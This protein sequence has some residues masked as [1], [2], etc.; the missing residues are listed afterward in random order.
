MLGCRTA[1]GPGTEE[2]DLDLELQREA[3]A[4]AS[5]QDAPAAT[6]ETATAAA[7]EAPKGKLTRFD[8]LRG[9]TRNGAGFRVLARETPD[10]GRVVAFEF[11]G[12]LTLGDESYKGGKFG[13]VALVAFDAEGKLRWSKRLD[14]KD[15]HYVAALEVAA[16][17]DI[18]IG[19]SFGQQGMILTRLSS[20]GE[21]LWTFEPEKEPK[22][23]EVS[24]FVL[25]AQGDVVVS[26]LF[27]R[28]LQLPG[29]DPMKSRYFDG[30]VGKLDGQ[31]G[32]IRWIQ[33]FSSVEAKASAVYVAPETGD[34]F[35]GGD[36]RKFLK[37]GGKELSGKRAFFFARFSP[38]GQVQFLAEVIGRFAGNVISIQPIAG[39]VAVL[40]LRDPKNSEL[41]ALS[42]KDGTIRWVAEDTDEGGALV[43]D[44]NRR[45][46]AVHYAVHD[47]DP[48]FGSTRIL[49]REIE[50]EDRVRTV[51]AIDAGDYVFMSRG[52]VRRAADGAILISG[53]L[54]DDA[55][56][57]DGF[58][59]YLLDLAPDARRVNLASIP[60]TGKGSGS[61][62]KQVL[63]KK[64]VWRDLRIAVQ[65]QRRQLLTCVADPS[66]I[67]A[68]FSLQPDGTVSEVT[69]LGELSEEQSAC[70][71]A[72][73]QE[74]R[75]CPYE[76]G[77]YK[78]RLSQLR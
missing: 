7:A 64:Q 30:Y 15:Y 40:H 54:R 57:N 11:D 34:I 77:P 56:D 67:G 26:G 36:Y 19:G 18:L 63:P 17:G 33:Q 47:A 12:T 42:E 59:P 69:V 3:E 1:E 24:S 22:W 43:Y 28:N 51:K 75:V 46:D 73:L 71:T 76:G 37:V 29:R 45:P 39:E 52:T 5:G 14:N 61:R 20:A 74:T 35:V 13:G 6:G 32:A 68:E 31:T 50:R 60:A 58:Y 27:Q 8:L 78:R 66:E 10:S 25:D 49:V 48:R 9:K 44:A 21:P 16:N 72:V 2:P 41:V 55:W 70:V 4:I 53:S 23:A 38:D 62:C 65:Q